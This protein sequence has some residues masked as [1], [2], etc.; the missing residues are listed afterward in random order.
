M[1]MESLLTALAVGVLGGG[2]LFLTLLTLPGNWLLLLVAVGAQAWAM[3]AGTTLPYSPWTLA[4][5]VALAVAAEV[6]ETAMG[7]AGAKAGGARGRGAWGA[8]IGSI[9]GAL[10]GTVALAF[11]PLAGT[12]LGALAGAAVGAMAGE[13]T[14]GDRD[15][16][17]TVKPAAG[18]AIGRFAGILVKFAIGVLMWVVAVTAAAWD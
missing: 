10:V 7:A 12:L 5:L 3:F 1:T 4:A 18:A 2:S 17:D 14:Y 9:V 8:M 11:L 13:L 16:L 6:A 15:A